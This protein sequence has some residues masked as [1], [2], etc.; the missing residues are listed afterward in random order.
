MHSY[1]DTALRKL[2]VKEAH[3][4]VNIMSSK[5]EFIYLR[6]RIPERARERDRHTDR[7]T[8]RQ[9]DRG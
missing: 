4:T 1:S 7:Q 6:E 8:D 9:T 3:A 5:R 2:A